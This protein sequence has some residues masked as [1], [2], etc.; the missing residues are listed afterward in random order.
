MDL[1]VPRNI[2]PSVGELE[3]VYLFDIDDLQGLVDRNHQARQQVL[4]AS[5]AIVGRKADRFLAWWQ[6][7]AYAA[8]V[9][10]WMR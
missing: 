9:P 1:G 2:E 3:N 5:Q 7:E 8:P 10:P 6:Q 4:E